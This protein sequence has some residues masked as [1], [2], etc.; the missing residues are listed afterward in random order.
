MCFDP[1]VDDTDVER[2]AVGPWPRGGTIWCNGGEGPSGF[3][4]LFSD[5][6]M[7]AHVIDGVI[8]VACRWRF[9]K[10]QPYA[11]ASWVLKTITENSVMS[12]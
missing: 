7:P 3:E 10:I 2:R 1:V 9:W 5:S 8:S 6:V 11:E 4:K 12:A